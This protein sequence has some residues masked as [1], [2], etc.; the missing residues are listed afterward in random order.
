MGHKVFYLVF[1]LMV[2]GGCG[3]EQKKP[4]AKK[5]NET[6]AA[7]LA[8]TWQGDMEDWLIVIDANGHVTR[9]RVPIGRVE[10]TPDKITK[11]P[12]KQGGQGV[13][14]PGQWFVQYDPNTKEMMVEINIKHFKAR[15]GKNTVEG[16]SRDVF[17][18]PVEPNGMLWTADWV[19]EPH[20]LASTDKQKKIAL[21]V[22][23]N[24]YYKGQVI[25]KKV[26]K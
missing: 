5:V 17:V 12:M 9:A 22:D 3:E 23:P 1:C 6:A 15:M 11:V 25:F 24:E 26:R 13:Y 16:R 10:M 7:F 20:Y 4:A 14:K 21:A 8:G 18:G 2:L 19:S